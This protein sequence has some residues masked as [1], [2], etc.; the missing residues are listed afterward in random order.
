MNVY[1]SMSANG[2]TLDISALVES[3]FIRAKN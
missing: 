1:G 3:L 2:A